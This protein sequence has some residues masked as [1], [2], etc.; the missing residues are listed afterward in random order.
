VESLGLPSPMGAME[1]QRGG[2]DDLTA[3]QALITE[4]LGDERRVDVP[5]AELMDR[6]RAMGQFS[7][8]AEV[9]PEGRELRSERAIWAKVVQRFYGTLFTNGLKF[10]ST[11]PASR[12]NRRMIISRT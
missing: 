5:S 3:F 11:D 8:L 4:M 12:T 9:E 2:D 10:A 7:F 6:A 1:L